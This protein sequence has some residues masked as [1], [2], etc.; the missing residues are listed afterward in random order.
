MDGVPLT[1]Y[2]RT[3]LRRLMG[4]VSQETVLL[5]DT[6][7]ANIAYGLK[8]APLEQVRAAARAANADEFIM[9]LPRPTTPCWASAVRGSP[10]GNGSASRSPGAAA[11]SPILILDEATSA[12]DTE[13]ERSCRSDRPPDGTAPCSSLRI[14]S[15]RCSTPIHPRPGEGRSWSGAITIISS[16]PMAC[17]GAC[18]TSSSG[19]DML[20]GFTL[21]RNPSKSTSHRP[22]DPLGAR[23]CD[24]VVVNVGK[25]EDDTRDLVASID[26]RAS[27]SSTRWTSPS[28][29]R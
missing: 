16:P 26:D 17:I 4:I 15:R 25:S 5:N 11:R 6:V 29:T 12:L 14:A 9:R 24:E 3:S 13:S 7:L 21:V 10:A 20:S 22:R 23:V 27:A 19:P 28:A 1:S 8:G 18:T 2:T